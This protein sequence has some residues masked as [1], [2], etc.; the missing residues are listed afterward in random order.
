[1]GADLLLWHFDWKAGKTE[2]EDEKN[3]KAAIVATRERI[4]KLSTAFKNME[5]ILGEDYAPPAD[6]DELVMS[7]GAKA[8]ELLLRAQDRFRKRLLD[9]LSRVQQ[10]FQEGWRSQCVIHVGKW[11]VMCIGGMSWGDYPDEGGGGLCE[12]LDH[13]ELAEVIDHGRP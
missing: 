12:A 5:Y 6:Y 4:K 7:D 9:D 13:L 11:S 3:F 10:A 2:K 1:M 8:A